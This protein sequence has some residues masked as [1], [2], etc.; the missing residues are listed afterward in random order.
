MATRLADQVADHQD[1]ARPRR[2]RRIAVGRVA[3]TRQ[4]D[5]RECRRR[6][7]VYVEPPI[8]TSPSTYDARYSSHESCIRCV[9]PAVN[10]V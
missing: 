6:Q 8:S 10:S 5:L 4:A 7:I 1:T 2:A 3:Q 9:C